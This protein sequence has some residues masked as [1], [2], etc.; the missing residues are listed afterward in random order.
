MIEDDALREV[1]AVPRRLAGDQS[2]AQP[3]WIQTCWC[4]PPRVAR[5]RRTNCCSASNRQTMCSFCRL[6]R[7]CRH[8]GRSCQTCDSC[9]PVRLSV[10]ELE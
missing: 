5:D 7:I 6:C 3:Y 8:R 4:A 1:R 2:H 9:T 10:E